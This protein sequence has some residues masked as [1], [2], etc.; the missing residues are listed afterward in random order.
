MALAKIKFTDWINDK[1]T[2]FEVVEVLDITPE[3]QSEIFACG[4]SIDGC[5][6]RIF[7][8]WHRHLPLLPGV[9]LADPLMS[10]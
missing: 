3:L 9:T 6:R 2:R 7:F 1:P 8:P 5:S 4:Q 10:I